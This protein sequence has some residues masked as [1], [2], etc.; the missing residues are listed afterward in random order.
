MQLLF[1]LQKP[2]LFGGIVEVD[3]NT[4][5]YQYYFDVD[6]SY[7]SDLNGASFH[8]GSLYMGSLKNKF[9][10]VFTPEPAK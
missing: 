8:D 3:A 4:G 9:V 2:K 6:G 1:E 5:E 7:I 10:A